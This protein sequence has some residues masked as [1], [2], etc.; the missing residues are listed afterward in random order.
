MLSRHCPSYVASM[1]PA[2][3]ICS[4]V[5]T[6][7]LVARLPD[8]AESPP[9]HAA[10]APASASDA[11]DLSDRRLAAAGSEGSTVLLFACA[12]SGPL[13]GEQPAGS[14]EAAAAAG[15]DASAAAAE[16][17]GG[18]AGGE[19]LRLVC[20]R[21]AAK[22]CAARVLPVGAC[23][24]NLAGKSEACG[25]CLTALP[26]PPA[27]QAPVAA[28]PAAAP[29]APAWKTTMPRAAPAARRQA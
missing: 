2:N 1:L 3:P 9:R 21:W 18:P 19:A 15:P 23:P 16:S 20:P 17:A 26:P 29:P 27:V 4:P 13:P 11:A 25:P 28:A 6:C 5:A 12:P 24:V 10:G 7:W 8:A 14:G 22:M